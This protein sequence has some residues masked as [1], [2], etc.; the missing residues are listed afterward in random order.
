ML[1]SPRRESE[2]EMNLRAP[3]EAAPTFGR[4]G[5]VSAIVLFDSDALGQVARTIDIAAS[6]NRDVIGQ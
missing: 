3:N 4:G 5:F 1:K 2:A 6:Q